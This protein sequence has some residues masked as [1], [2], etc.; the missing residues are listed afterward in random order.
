MF[1]RRLTGGCRSPKRVTS[2]ARDCTRVLFALPAANDLAPLPAEIASLPLSSVVITIEPAEPADD[3]LR[4]RRRGRGKEGEGRKE[5]EGR[6][7]RCRSRRR[8]RSRSR[9][10]RR[11][12][13]RSRRSCM[14]TIVWPCLLLWV[15]WSG[16]W[17]KSVEGQWKVPAAAWSRVQTSVVC[18]DVAC[19]PDI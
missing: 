16:S 5:R 18:D 10:E 3:G 11:S 6:R 4:N 13:R 12:E 9:S 19:L 7:G 17:W 15:A 8:S 2:P 1:Y 14:S